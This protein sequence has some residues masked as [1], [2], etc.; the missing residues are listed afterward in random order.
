MWKT[1]ILW[2]DNGME[3]VYCVNHKEIQQMMMRGGFAAFSSGWL[4]AILDGLIPG[5]N[6]FG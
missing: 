5:W 2:E 4:R 6:V 1:T 3:D